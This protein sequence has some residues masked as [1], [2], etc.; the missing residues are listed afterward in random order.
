MSEIFISYA[1]EDRAKAQALAQ[2]LQDQ[3]W[4]VWWDKV[5]P[6][7][8]KY[9]DVI[10]AELASAKA[11]IVLWSRASVASDWVK[12]E[13]QEGA[14]RNVLVPVL[15]DKVSP[16]YGF[17]QVQ[18]ADLSDWD[19]SASHA[20]LQSMV[21]RIGE[22]INKPVS[23]S[24]FRNERIPSNRSR[25]MIY[26]GIGAVA[27]LLLGFFAYRL[28]NRPAGENKNNGGGISNSNGSASEASPCN[29][30]SR[31][32]AADLTSKGL[33][34]IDPGA[35]YEAARLE[36]N[37]AIL[38]CAKYPDA[39][40]WRAQ[41]L[42][43]LQ[44]SDRAVADF[45]KFLE[46]AAADDNNRQKA[47]RLLADLTSPP[48]TPAPTRPPNANT[49]ATNGNS[50]SHPPNTGSP[51]PHP[52]I[53]PA[54]VNEM[55]SADKSTRIAATTRFIVE[56]KQ[57]PNAVKQSVRNALANLDNKSGVIN[58]LVYLES[59]DPAILKQ[60]KADIQKLLD[61]ARPN[62]DQTLQHVNQVQALLNK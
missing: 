10:G 12:D 51:T 9:G 37:E 44:Q 48:P 40:F 53:P 7:G 8:M 49:V 3:H 57:D 31:H 25:F 62:G 11:V 41:S 60:N 1:R 58:T 45:K 50:N 56:R 4:N 55:F 35:N 27:I 6:P 33:L 52:T 13:A 15:I 47:Q 32:K 22:L 14:N 26:G 39:Y 16:P 61:A 36:F 34:D 46:L 23:E 42:I 28:M 19:G 29:T 54:Q 2:L 21:H 30:D 38:E 43:A 20:E 5:I 18:T 17:R 24:A 59:V